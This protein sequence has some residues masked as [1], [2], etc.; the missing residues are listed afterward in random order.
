MITYTFSF[1]GHTYTVTANNVTEA[2]IQ[3]RKLLRGAA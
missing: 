1:Q 3:Y 2:L